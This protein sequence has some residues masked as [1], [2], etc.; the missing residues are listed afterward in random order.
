M[1]TKRTNFSR[2]EHHRTITI[3]SGNF[4][5]ITFIRAF[6]KGEEEVLQ[7]THHRLQISPLFYYLWGVMKDTEYDKKPRNFQ[8]LKRDITNEF[9]YI[10]YTM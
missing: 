2:M 3:A 10:L 8:H 4:L 7:S 6:D 5:R 1:I 9:N